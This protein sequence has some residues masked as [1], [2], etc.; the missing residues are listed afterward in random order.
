MSKL[1]T[2]AAALTLAASVASANQLPLNTQTSGGSGA[3][4]TVGQDGALGGL[5]ANSA[6]IIGLAVVAVAAAAGGGGSSATTTN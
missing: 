3:E 1:L 4:V 2:S 6:I 5:G